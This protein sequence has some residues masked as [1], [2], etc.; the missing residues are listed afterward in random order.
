MQNFTP[1]RKTS[2]NF[3]TNSFL[4]TDTSMQ[5][6]E[7]T[8]QNILAFAAVYRAQEISDEQYVSYCLN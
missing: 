5:P 2:F 4:Q 8:I 6:S 1:P 3:R 7:Q